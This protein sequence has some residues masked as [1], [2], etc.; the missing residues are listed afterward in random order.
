MTVVT[1]MEPEI[2]EV[3]PRIYRVSHKRRPIAK[4]SKVDISHYFTFFLPSLSS[5][6]RF[7][8]FW[9]FKKRA[10]FLGN[11]VQDSFSSLLNTT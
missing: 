4:I 9:I 11:P 6:S 8:I 1:N 5:L 3:I 7:V 2:F 10:S